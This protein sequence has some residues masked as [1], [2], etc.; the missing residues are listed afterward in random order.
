MLR[1]SPS[2]QSGVIEAYRAGLE[3]AGRLNSPGGELVILLATRLVEGTHTASAL[4][5][6]SRELRAAY[7]A[8]V[9][10]AETESADVIDGIFKTA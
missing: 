9:K 7:D 1:I 8:A 6:L 10:D 5:S 2:V 4:A 3:A